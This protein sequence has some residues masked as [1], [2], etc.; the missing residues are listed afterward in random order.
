MLPPST[1]DPAQRIRCCILR[2]WRLEGWIMDDWPTNQE[3]AQFLLEQADDIEWN[4]RDYAYADNLRARATR[5]LDD[6]DHK[7]PPF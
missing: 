6:P 4:H 5:L 1:P 2:R 7:E 3:R